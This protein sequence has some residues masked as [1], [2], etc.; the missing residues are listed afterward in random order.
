MPSETTPSET[1]PTQTTPTQTTPSETR[2]AIVIGSGPGGLTAAAYLAAAGKSVIVLEQHDIAGGNCQVF[3]R[4]H[5][6]MEFEFDVGL[7]YIG[8]CGP[9]GFFPR[10]FKSLG[11][12]DRIEY[13]E[14]DPDGFDTIMFPD[15]EFKVPR[16]WDNYKDRLIDAF[17]GEREAIEQYMEL[18]RK[19][20]FEFRMS[21]IPG[22]STP[23]FDEWGNRPLS[24]LF[25][26]CGLSQ[27]AIAVLDHWGG[28]Y[29]SGPEQSIVSIHALLV[30][31]YMDGAYYPK[32]GGQVFPA[33]LVQVIEAL[34]G[35]VRTLAKV[36][37]ILIEDARVTGVELEGGEVIEAPLVV[38]NAD[39][40]RTVLEFTGR[41]RWSK[42]A[43]E[44]AENAVMSIGLIVTYV[45]VDI[46]LA[47]DLP[48]SNFMYFPDS[49][50]GGYYDELEAGRF[51]AVID[52]AGPFTFVAMASRKDP[53]QP[54]LCPPGYTNFQ[55]MTMA[56]RGYSVWGVEDG[57]GE[58]G[59][60]RLNSDYRGRKEWISERMIETA[61]K[62]LGPFRDHIVHQ[63]TATPLTQ[64]RYTLSTGGTSYGLRFN[65]GQ[66]RAPYKSEIEGLYFVGASTVSGH[67]I[68]GAMVGGI[69]C[70]GEILGRPIIMEV[71]TGQEIVDP[72]RIPEDPPDFDPYEFSRGLALRSKRAEGRA[73]RAVVAAT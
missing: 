68:G 9:D 4:H 26:H 12:G 61:E 6:G 13:N 2:D 60:Y 40:K 43:V 10:I 15:R 44:R 47:K 38:S 70:A 35:E 36:N 28:L 49:D 5:Q 23:V 18:L 42:E 24:D 34:G 30:D 48:N 58:G 73:K 71:M 50:I 55:I 57:P 53:G 39:Y 66:E 64:E 31:H 14:L 37:K 52:E 17:P 62:M 72:E 33:R 11:V 27:E 67:G 25:E 51:P 45:V 22:A 54:H 63:E 56:P 20:G 7:H 46:D 19:V 21:M 16:G 69:M 1:T 8:A 59:K 65:P 3:R 29:G 41:D 32:G